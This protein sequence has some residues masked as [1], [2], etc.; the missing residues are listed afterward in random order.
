MKKGIVFGISLIL[1]IGL[2]LSGC[3]DENGENGD[4]TNGTSQVLDASS[5][6]YSWS[7]THP[8]EMDWEWSYSVKNIGTEQMKMRI[9]MRE[10]DGSHS[11]MIFN[12]EL[13]KGWTFDGDHWEEIPVDFYNMWYEN[14]FEEFSRHM[15]DFLKDWDGEPIEYRHPTQGW[16]WRWHGIEINPNLS[17]S[18]F[19]M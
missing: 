2:A 7:F 8:T 16:T 14:Y 9:E 11:G 5:L 4:G 17:D 19:E 3:I 18:L 12:Q 6:R 1:L 10:E 13:N 15:N